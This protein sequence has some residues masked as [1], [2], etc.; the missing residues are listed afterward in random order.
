MEIVPIQFLLVFT[1]PVNLLLLVYMSALITGH[2]NLCQCIEHDYILLLSGGE[3]RE[4]LL[5]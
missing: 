4:R 1:E 3:V 2:L 5:N